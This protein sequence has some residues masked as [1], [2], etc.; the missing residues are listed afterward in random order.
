MGKVLEV[1]Y[2]LIGDNMQT[3]EFSLKDGRSILAEYRNLMYMEQG[4]RL[5]R[6]SDDHAPA[7]WFKKVVQSAYR[8][9][10][11]KGLANFINDDLLAR[12]VVFGPVYPGRILPIH[13]LDY[14]QCV[15]VKSENFLCCE[16]DIRFEKLY[17]KTLMRDGEQYRI[18]FEKMTGK[19]HVFLQSGGTL[20]Q[21]TLETGE[22]IRVDSQCLL[23]FTS[24]VELDLQWIGI[25]NQVVATNRE[26]ILTAITGPGTV[27]LQSIPSDHHEY[28]KSMAAGSDREQ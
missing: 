24:G 9:E 4:I 22:T 14:H 21:K 16:S 28:K 25:I 20:T 5:V 17:S 15:Y 13:L 23:A 8:I 2:E 7:N 11:E 10:R 26:I 27:W 12:K 18:T 1:P 6:L 19:N 3:I